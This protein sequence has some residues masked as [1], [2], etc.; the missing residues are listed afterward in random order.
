MR[1]NRLN[2]VSS[3]F[4]CIS[5]RSRLLK[6]TSALG[7]LAMERTTN[8][9]LEIEPREVDLCYN[10]FLSML[11]IYAFLDSKQGECDKT[12][13]SKL[14]ICSSQNSAFIQRRMSVVNKDI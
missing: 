6:Q 3:V 12:G 13:S 11:H 4:I 9:T 14:G 5:P 7:V 8:K 10:F 1:A 2:Q